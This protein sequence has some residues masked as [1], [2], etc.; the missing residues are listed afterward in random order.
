[1]PKQ[2]NAN[3][4]RISLVIRVVSKQ[5]LLVIAS[6]AKQSRSIDTQPFSGLLRHSVPRKDKTDC[7]F[8]TSLLRGV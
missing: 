5:F 3:W 4:K 8:V 6:E 1:V 2:G 7:Y